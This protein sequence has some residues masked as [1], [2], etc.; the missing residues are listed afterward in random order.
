MRQQLLFRRIFATLMLLCAF[1]AISWAYDFMVDGIYYSKGSSTVQVTSRSNLYTGSYTGSVTIPSTVTYSGKEYEVTG[2]EGHAFTGC[3]DLTSI[4]LPKSLKTIGTYA[5]FGCSSL[6]SITIP[7]GVTKISEKTFMWC[8]QLV[9]VNL[10]KSLKTIEEGAFYKCTSLK[11]ITIPMAVE[12]IGKEAFL[13]CPLKEVYVKCLTPPT[14]NTNVFSITM[15]CCLYVPKKAYGLYLS[16]AWDDVFSSIKTIDKCATTLC[17]PKDVY[18]Y[19]YAWASYD[20]IYSS[21]P[22][23]EDIYADVVSEYGDTLSFNDISISMFYRSSDPDVVSISRQY[24]EAVNRA[25]YTMTIHNR[26]GNATIT[27]YFAGNDD[28]EASSGS[29]EVY[30]SKIKSSVTFPQ[31]E[32]KWTA[33]RFGWSNIDIF[34]WDDLPEYD[35]RYHPLYKPVATLKWNGRSLSKEG[36]LTYTCDNPNVA[37]IDSK[38][39]RLIRVRPGTATI[40]ATYS[41]NLYV[42]GSSASYTLNVAIADEDLYIEKDLTAQ[43]STDWRNWTGATGA[44]S[45]QFAPLVKTNDGRRVQ[46]CER[47]DSESATVGTVLKRR[48]TGLPN[49]TYRIEL[50]GAAAS[51]A[52]R[53]SNVVYN[54][55]FYEGDTTVVYL[56]A[57]TPSTQISKYIPIHWATSL[58]EVTTAVFDEVQV[59]DGTMEIGMCSE[60]NCTNWHL[61]QIKGI[62]QMV[63]TEE[64]HADVLRQAQAALED[65]TYA[66]ITGEERTALEQAIAD[67]TT[68]SERTA[69]AFLTAINA[70]ETA[71]AT[72]K[73]AKEKYETITTSYTISLSSSPVEGGSVTGAGSYEE[74]NTVTVTATANAGYQF[75]Q[76]IENGAQVST[77]ATYSFTATADRSLTAMFEE[78]IIDD[79]IYIETDLT[80][81]FTA[82]WQNWTGATGYTSTEFAPL[83]AT[84]DGR[85]VQVCERYDG[86]SA[87]EGTVFKRTLTG[88]TNGIYRIELYGAA[89]STKGR[90]GHI[91]SEMTEADEGN[92]TAVYLYAHTPSTQIAKYIPVHWATSFTEVAT[93]VL[94]E[95]EVTDGTLEIGMYSE[96]KFTNWHV[97]QIKGITALVDAKELHSNM[98][99]QALAALYDETYACITGEE[100]TALALAIV[101]NTDIS[102]HTAEAY[103]AAISALENA[104]KVYADAKVQYEAF[105]AAKRMVED[106]SYPYAAEYKR[107]AAEAAAVATAGSAAEATGMK[108]A[109]FAAWRQYAESSALLEGIEGSSDVTAT[110]IKNPRAE[111]EIDGAVWQMVMAEGTSGGI[112]IL[113]D[114]SWTDG[115]GNSEHRYFD[116]GNWFASAWDVTF[117][118]DISLPAGRYQLTALGRSELDVAMTLFAGEATAEMAHHSTTGGL[119]NRGW[120]QT[121]VEFELKEPATLSI[122]VRGVTSVVHNWM[123]FSDFR[124]VQFPLSMTG[125]RLT[126]APSLSQRG[127]GESIYDLSGRRIENGQLPKGIYIVNGK[128]VM[129]K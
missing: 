31:K 22:I 55:L 40:T 121:S 102:E 104:I 85:E 113:G 100:R 76:W 18:R 47:Y 4:S 44:T 11:S 81:Q 71:T 108:E 73:A 105:A 41:G 116:G 25:F 61:I 34:Q 51:T 80:A 68:V 87:T 98:L 52:E 5:F 70:L 56:Y 114:Q 112:K 69:T 64:L 19:T 39:G 36:L 2:I 115:N 78:Q 101:E 63:N 21:Y 92:E 35:G 123:S 106:R 107:T 125:I 126:P 128:K 83:V 122:G 48:L 17:F 77:D 13:Y 20:E 90:D 124:L 16:S 62:T 53:D 23:K 46:L 111:E 57:N 99:R 43:F 96:K 82:D 86:S 3:T 75:V 54:M 110:Y 103:Q 26:I 118:Q 29:C 72:F 117:K 1:S 65:E 95:V 79:H 59:T 74:G 119:F 58:T 10:P 91:D 45:T 88:L 7:E 129:I 49:G 28:Y 8:T 27:G 33:D 120:E 94:D 6:T 97:V 38:T 50:Y 12:S 15:G 24:Y 109:L 14:L 127:E 84:N 32:F 60:L 42:E 93:A 37:E 66:C 30:F 9:T 89:A 67:N